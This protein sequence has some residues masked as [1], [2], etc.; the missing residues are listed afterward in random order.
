MSIRFHGAFQLRIDFAILLSLVV[1]CPQLVGKSLKAKKGRV[2]FVATS[3]LLRNTWG[4]NQDTYLA[5]LRLPKVAEPVLV[6]LVDEYPA[7]EAPLS[8]ADLTS[9]L[10]VRIAVVRD[11]GC[12]GAF[13]QLLLRAAPGDLIALLNEPMQYRP[14]LEPAPTPDSI[15]P[16]YRVVR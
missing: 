5:F 1:A 8:H 16:C 15:L 3:T 9:D 14:N 10:E 6:R 7:L 12:K 11:D 13:S 2:H 4:M